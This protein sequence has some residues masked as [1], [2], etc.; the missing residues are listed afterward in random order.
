MKGSRDA[1]RGEDRGGEMEHGYPLLTGSLCV[2]GAD[3]PH[4][5]KGKMGSELLL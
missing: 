3:M 5:L 4:G 2:T 1:K